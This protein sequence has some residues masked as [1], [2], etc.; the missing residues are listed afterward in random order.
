MSHA[1]D[2]VIA[3]IDTDKH[4]QLADRFDIQ[5]LPAYWFFNKSATQDTDAM[6]YTGDH[7][8]A[9]V[10]KELEDFI[11]T[12]GATVPEGMLH[13]HPIHPQPWEEIEKAMKERQQKE[14]EKDAKER[15][16]QV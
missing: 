7:N 15:A 14:D 10:I 1:D 2:V 9:M 12:G 6:K 11:T 8:G 13:E 4:E 3:A 16:E 5:G